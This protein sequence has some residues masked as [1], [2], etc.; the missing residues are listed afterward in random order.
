MT[1]DAS[2]RNFVVISLKLLRATLT[3]LLPAA[4]A[5]E[6]SD[7]QTVR[8]VKKASKTTK[9]TKAKFAQREQLT[10]ASQ[11][12]GTI[13]NKTVR[14]GSTLVIFAGLEGTG[15][16]MVCACL[17]RRDRACSPTRPCFRHDALLEHHVKRLVYG[18]VAMYGERSL[19]RAMGA[20]QQTLSELAQSPQPWRRMMFQCTNNKN[21]TLGFKWS[22]PDS[23]MATGQRHDHP[24]A[25]SASE[26]DVTAHGDVAQL[27][28]LAERAG[29]DARIVVLA[30]APWEGSAHSRV[31]T[32]QPF[33]ARVRKMRDEECALAGQLRS[34]DPAFYHP[35]VYE[36]M[37]AAPRPTARALAAFLGADADE[38]EA[39]FV[40]N[41]RASSKP[42]P[43]A[44]QR[45]FAAAVR[46][47]ACALPEVLER[48]DS[49]PRW[50]VKR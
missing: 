10:M 21:S 15:H 25:V 41:L 46:T 8:A 17:P 20:L 32:K 13:L 3:L 28:M 11:P 39:S 6:E 35:L 45:R 1:A 16:H 29:V 38:V 33:E 42:P 34:L 4:L 44:A 27:A 19:H 24:D 7:P 18:S 31:S 5:S 26:G 22:Y 49:M 2:R 36:H 48:S 9:L 23:G 43:D 47:P 12:P 40:A 14:T 37:M 50:A 30:R